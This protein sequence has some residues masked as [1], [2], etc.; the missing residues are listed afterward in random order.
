MVAEDKDLKM[1]L[2][3]DEIL[4]SECEHL[5]K[6]LESCGPTAFLLEFLK[7]ITKLLEIGNSLSIWNHASPTSLY[8]CRKQKL[9]R[10]NTR[11][12]R[13]NEP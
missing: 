9:C 5:V 1:A 10:E 13:K 3:S 8:I 7:I 6:Y 11:K 4:D 12:P 2:D